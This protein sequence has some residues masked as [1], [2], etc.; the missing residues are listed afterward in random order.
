MLISA[1]KYILDHFSDARKTKFSQHEVSQVLT[2]KI[3]ALFV[4]QFLGKDYLIKGSAG[5]GNWAAVPWVAFLNPAVTYTTT[6]GY[7]VAYLFK[8]DMSG[9]YLALVLGFDELR[10]KEV[11][12]LGVLKAKA[13][14]F[15][16]RVQ[17]PSLHFQQGPVSIGALNS[18]SD[19][20]KFY[21][22]GTVLHR[23]YRKEKL[24]PEEELIN[25]LTLILIEYDRLVGT[26]P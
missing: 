19:Y 5:K 14:A 2:E 26:A 22:A 23:F 7:F 9:F 17:K 25:D 8:E 10:G 13:N 18:R 24:P 1:F 15:K 16:M 6:Q 3:P 12:P 21:E 4:K 11:V 20:P